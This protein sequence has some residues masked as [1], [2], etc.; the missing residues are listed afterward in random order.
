MPSYMA[1]AIERDRERHLE[2]Y[3]ANRRRDTRQHRVR[4]HT[5]ARCTWPRV[6]SDDCKKPSREIPPERIERKCLNCG[7]KFIAEGRLIRMCRDHR[8][9]EISI[10]ETRGG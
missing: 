4:V 3:R 1:E 5:G 7:R 6:K 2:R 10:K 8:H 9:G